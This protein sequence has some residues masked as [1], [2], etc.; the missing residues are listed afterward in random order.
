VDTFVVRVWTPA[1]PE[2]GGFETELQGVV[3]HVASGASSRFTRAAEL[4]ELLRAMRSS[5]G[6]EGVADVFVAPS[7]GLGERDGQGVSR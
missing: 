7:S 3:E 6:R 2:E 5:R 1:E 4:A